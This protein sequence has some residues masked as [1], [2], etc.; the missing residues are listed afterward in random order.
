MGCPRGDATGTG[1]LAGCLPC[2]LRQ[3]L[4]VPLPP[5]P[6]HGCRRVIL[7]AQEKIGKT[8][9]VDGRLVGPDIAD[10]GAPQRWGIHRPADLLVFVP[11]DVVVTNM[12]AL[13]SAVSTSLGAASEALLQQLG[14]LALPSLEEEGEGQEEGAGTGNGADSTAAAPKLAAQN[15]RGALLARH[16][17]KRLLAQG[18]QGLCVSSN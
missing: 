4:T 18:S 13:A 16:L 2:L 5:P 11:A 14:S 8:Y 7:W 3:L 10:S 9:L 12:E 15:S 6:S 17:S 1:L